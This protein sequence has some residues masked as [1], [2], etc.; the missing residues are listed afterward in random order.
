MDRR[1]HLMRVGRGRLPHGP[2]YACTEC[3][4]GWCALIFPDD[5]AAVE[6]GL[7]GLKPGLRNWW[8]PDDPT[9]PDRPIDPVTEPGPMS[10][11][12]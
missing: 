8:H 1:L 2:R 4:W 11:E 3:H 9:N 10:E 5:I 6:A 7:M 12:L